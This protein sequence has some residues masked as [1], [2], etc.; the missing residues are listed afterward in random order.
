MNSIEIKKKLMGKGE[1]CDPCLGRQI[2]L[3]HQGIS[4]GVIGAAL[5]KAETESEIDKIIEKQP[6]PEIKENCYLCEGLISDMPEI[7]SKLIKETEKWE[8]NDFLVGTKVPGEIAENEEKIWTEV[9]PEDAEPIKRQVN[10]ETGKKIEQE[11]GKEA[12]FEDPDITFILNFKEN[13]VET[14]IKSIYIYGRYKKL[15]RGIPQTKWPCTH[16]NGEGCEKC[17]NTGQQFPYT[18]QGIMEKPLL[19]MTQAKES[20]FHGQGR[21]DRDALMLGNG[22][23]FVIEAV[24]PVKRNIDLDKFLQKIKKKSEGKIEVKDLEYSD[25][26]KVVELKSKRS[27]KTYEVWV[28]AKQE[29]NEEHLERIEEEFQ[30]ETIEQRTPTRVNHRRA[31]KVRKRNIQLIE[32]K[33]IGPNKFKVKVRTEAGAYVKELVSGDYGRTRPS[34]AEVMKNSLT[35]EKLNVVKIHGSNGD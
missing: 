12:E 24:N 7:H 20:K 32:T 27:D 10:R 8:F 4:N 13:K 14:Q 30:D 11:T 17:D 16:C 28:K 23:P 21:E 19:E 22:R 9:P 6:D 35:P 33:K 15:E 3:K 5:R 29:V 2:T 1:I 25:K 26:D 31:D 34:F 18:V